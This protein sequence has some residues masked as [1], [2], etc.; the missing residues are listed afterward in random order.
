MNY[1]LNVTS[2][3]C[4]AN[5]M[6]NLNASMDVDRYSINLHLMFDLINYSIRYFRFCC[7]PTMER[8]MSLRSSS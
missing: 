3:Y 8:E 4:Q 5:I 1:S 7:K 6:N 2:L